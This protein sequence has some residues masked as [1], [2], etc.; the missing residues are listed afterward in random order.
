MTITSLFWKLFEQGGAG[1]RL[2]GP[3]GLP[4]FSRN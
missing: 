4:F 3:H 2:G 1:G